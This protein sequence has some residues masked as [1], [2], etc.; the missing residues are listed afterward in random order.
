MGFK[1]IIVV[2]VVLTILSVFL[3]SLNSCKINSINRSSPE[4]NC[5]IHINS[6][7]KMIVKEQF[8]NE[9]YS[10]TEKNKLVF[11]IFMSSENK[12]DSIVFVKTD[13]N[14]NESNIRILKDKLLKINYSCIYKNYFQVQ[15]KPTSFIF[16][17][18]PNLQE[19]IK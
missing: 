11:S 14:Q 1:K 7:I 12:V 16:N 8:E 2:K 17:Y 13:F 3:I 6:E 5:S 15:P 4:P 9:K 19:F 10:I 18:N